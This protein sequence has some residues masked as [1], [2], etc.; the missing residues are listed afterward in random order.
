MDSL[1][2][3]ILL[4]AL[5]SGV[6]SMTVSAWL[7]FGWLE[8]LLDPMVSVSTGL[9]L[10]TALLHLLP[11]GFE[12]AVAPHT[13]G[14]VLLGGIFGF[15]ILEKISLMHHNHHHEGDGH[16]HPHGHDR[17]HAGRGGLQILIGDSVH[18]FVDGLLIAGAFL[19]DVHLGW[20]VTLSI[21]VHEVP[22]KVSDFMVLLNAGFT[23]G[24]AL[25]YNV[26]ITVAAV[27]GAVVGYLTLDR[28]QAWIPFAL[29]IAASSFIYIAMADL[30]PQL[31]RHANWRRTVPQVLLMAGGVGIVLLG[32]AFLD[33]H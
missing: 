21:V 8:R 13:L 3:I 2:L 10:A 16:H 17:E 25:A 28:M 18:N 15:F 26:M 7:S 20:V 31:Q 19:A 6:F 12:S 27:V 1:L 22:H 9:L 23:H 30:I 32:R 33:T 4:A 14:M 29:M 5:A 11:E 24:R